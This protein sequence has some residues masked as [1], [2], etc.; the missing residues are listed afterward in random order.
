MCV[1]L[2]AGVVGKCKEFMTRL[3]KRSASFRHM[4]NRDKVGAQ[5]EQIESKH[6]VTSI[7]CVSRFSTS[8]YH[9][10]LKLYESLPNYFETFYKFVYW[11]IYKPYLKSL[12]EGNKTYERS[13]GN[14][15]IYFFEHTQFNENIMQQ[16]KR[17]EKGFV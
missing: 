2:T 7:T 11:W 16:C 9:E 4:F 13:R 12:R 6:Y 8:Q 15:K 1:I 17:R 14:G 5:A 10:Y 3:I